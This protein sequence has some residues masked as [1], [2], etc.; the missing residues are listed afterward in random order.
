MNSGRAVFNH[1]LLSEIFGSLGSHQPREQIVTA[2]GRERNNQADRPIGKARR[3]VLRASRQRANQR[4]DR[5]GGDGQHARKP[6]RCHERTSSKPAVS[7]R[8][9]C[10]AFNLPAPQKCG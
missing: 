8:V 7:G 3:V 10:N 5:D 2:A 9:V 1:E 4:G 6:D